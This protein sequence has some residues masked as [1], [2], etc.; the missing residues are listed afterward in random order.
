[1]HN[2]KSSWGLSIE[3][4]ETPAARDI[5]FLYH[6]VWNLAETSQPLFKMGDYQGVPRAAEGELKLQ[7]ET[8]KCYTKFDQDTLGYPDNWLVPVCFQWSIFGLQESLGDQKHLYLY[9]LEHLKFLSAQI[10]MRMAMIGDL[11]AYYFNADFVNPEWVN[12]QQESILALILPKTHHLSKRIVAEDFGEHFGFWSQS[13]LKELWIES[14]IDTRYKQ[15]KTA[16]S[17]D[18]HPTLLNLEWEN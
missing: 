6:Y 7:Q 15:F 18:I 4:G 16:I 2:L 10:P 1:M 14:S 5:D 11:A 17:H 9:L 3:L 12:L 8:G 13:A